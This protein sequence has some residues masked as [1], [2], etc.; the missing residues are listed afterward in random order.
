MAALSLKRKVHARH[1][2]NR[3]DCVRRIYL[4]HE[5]YAC[6]RAEKAYV[7]SSAM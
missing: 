1:E 4:K 5:E 3:H 2:E 7:P 6:D